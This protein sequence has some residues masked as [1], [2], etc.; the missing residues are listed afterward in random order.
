MPPVVATAEW[1]HWY[2]HHPAPF[3]HRHAHPRR[4]RSRLGPRHSP[5]GTTTTS[6][7]HIQLNQPPQKPGLDTLRCLVFLG[8]WWKEYCFER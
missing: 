5:P 3:R 4:A 2:G 1:V 6:H 8:Q 7:H